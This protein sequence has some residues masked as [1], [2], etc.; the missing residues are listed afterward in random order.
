MHAICTGVIVADIFSSAVGSPPEAGQLILAEKFLLSAGGGAVN[1]A[2]CLGRIGAPARIVG[3][4]GHDLFGDFVVADLERRSIDPSWVMRS[5][6]HPTSTTFVLNV[7]GHD[8]RYIHTIGA[9]GDLVA[10]DVVP[11]L[12][13]AAVL[14]VGGYLALPGFDAAS[15]A[16]LFRL[17][18]QRSIATILDV[19]I[20]GGSRQPLDGIREA[21]PYADMFLPNQD[22]ARAL[23]G[24]E[25]PRRQAALLADLAPRC[26]VV[27]T[28]GNNGLLAR[29]GRQT[30][31]A[32]AYEM[33]TVDESCAGDAF[34]AGLIT[35]L[36]ERWP[37]ETSLRFAS[38]LGA[39]CTRA[40]G[41]TEGVFERDESLRFIERVPLE[42]H[43]Q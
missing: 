28:R 1:T 27:I 41:C 20:P 31:E 18:Q 30:W 13:D 25:S 43:T 29:R 34:A 39:S 38:A 32:G 17:A 7:K 40:L 37:F 35:G 23:T 15:L 26:T 8:R 36:M 5:Q 24:E 16:S 19:M 22:E 6:T 12:D 9:N 42:I 21:L 3:R 10:E 2:A 11:A 14:Y 4:V 33:E